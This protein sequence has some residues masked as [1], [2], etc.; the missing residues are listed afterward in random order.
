MSA[1]VQLN[2]DLWAAWQRRELS[3]E[4]RDLALL[5][6]FTTDFR[7]GELSTTL[8]AIAGELGWQ[9]ARTTTGRRLERLQRL[10]FV[11]YEVV[12]RRPHHRHVIRPTANLLRTGRVAQLSAT[13]RA[14]SRA[15]LEA[16]PSEALEAPGATIDAPSR[17]TVEEKRRDKT[18][19]P[20]TSTVDGEGLTTGS[21][22]GRHAIPAASR[23]ELERLGFRVPTGYD[24]EGRA[25][26]RDGVA[27]RERPRNGNAPVR[28]PWCA[29]VAGN[30]GGLASHLP[31]HGLTFADYEAWERS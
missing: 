7:T 2:L 18:S 30:R 13:T 28:C 10:G 23:V 15:P 17:A 22:N 25:A 8:D 14:A 21:G 1:F 26:R 16:A 11:E 31:A 12:G 3:A 20:P 5:V 9:V 27:L 6:A 29:L 4:E 24:A 19:S